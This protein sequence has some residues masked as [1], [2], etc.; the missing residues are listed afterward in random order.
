MSNN[1]L[2]EMSARLVRQIADEE[3]EVERAATQ[4]D[5][6]PRILWAQRL[7]LARDLQTQINKLTDTRSTN[8]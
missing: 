3:P 5:H 4:G 7:Q 8:P 2:K 1:N 6:W